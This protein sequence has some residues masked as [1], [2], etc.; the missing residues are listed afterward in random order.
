M[1]SGGGAAMSWFFAGGCF[2]GLGSQMLPFNKKII[3]NIFIY[4]THT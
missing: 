1:G 3:P 4:F 2:G